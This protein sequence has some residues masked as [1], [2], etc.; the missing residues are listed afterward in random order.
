MGKERVVSDNSAAPVNNAA[1]STSGNKKKI[2]IITI[3]AIIILLIIA[4]SAVSR[5][6]GY[7]T[8]KLLEAFNK[9]TYDRG[10]D[11]DIA[12]YDNMSLTSGDT[13]RT[14]DGGSYCRLVLDSD[15]YVFIEAN[16]EVKFEMAGRKNSSKTTLNLSYGAIENELENQLNSDESY[17]VQTPNSLMAVRGTRYRISAYEGA[18]G[19]FY[20]R[21][22]VF[23]GKVECR[24]IY[25][26]GSYSDESEMAE[27][28][29]EILIYYDEE[30]GITDYVGI[31]EEGHYVAEKNGNYIRDIK[32]E[33]LTKQVLNYMLNRVQNDGVVYEAISEDEI[34]KYISGELA[35][36]PEIYIEE[37][38]EEIAEALEENIEETD[39]ETE[40]EEE[41][42][43]EEIA[44]ETD[45]DNKETGS[46][47]EPQEPT[48]APTKAPTPVPT[49]VPVV[50]A[51]EIPVMLPM[52]GVYVDPALLNVPQNPAPAPEVQ[53]TQPSQ[54]SAPVV[55]NGRQ[56]NQ[57][58]LQYYDHDAEPRVEFNPDHGHG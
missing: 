19:I 55:E 7:R 13:L 58:W 6:K 21:I 36:E 1:E 18:D 56:E 28:G 14:G 47:E 46:E 41:S 15:K 50:S 44:E 20:T 39:V 49:Q 31:D 23:E 45:I 12:V 34:V 9:V 27:A 4:V 11:K 29:K 22:S 43:E 24:L 2:I 5:Q 52:D 30:N 54:P 42:D 3:I 48:P 38:V 10:A 40:V 8:I 53:P 16:S 32:Y 33:Q 17:E 25:P 26:D 35:E 57:W 37:I 51:N